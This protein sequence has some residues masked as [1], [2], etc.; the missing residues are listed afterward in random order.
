[1][2]ELDVRVYSSEDEAGAR[3]PAREKAVGLV[4]SMLAS[5]LNMIRLFRSSEF[6]LLHL[7]DKLQELYNKAIT[8]KALK[9]QANSGVDTGL[10]LELME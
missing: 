8:L 1:M 9:S 10:I 5:V 6:V 4:D 7:E 3:V 2:D